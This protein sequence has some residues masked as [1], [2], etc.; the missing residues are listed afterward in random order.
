[1]AMTTGTTRR[2]LEAWIF[3]GALVAK[4]AKFQWKI[5][6]DHF[7]SSKSGNQRRGSVISLDEV[8]SSGKK[9]AGKWRLINHNCDFWLKVFFPSCADWISCNIIWE[10]IFRNEVVM[11]HNICNRKHYFRLNDIH[12][13]LIFLFFARLYYLRSIYHVQWVRYTKPQTKVHLVQ[14]YCFVI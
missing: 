4:G 11:H 2:K 3:N 9:N 13:Q 7:A 8:R 10:K 1:M 6:L 14:Q 12:F 5:Q